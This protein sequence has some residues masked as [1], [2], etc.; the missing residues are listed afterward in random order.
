MSDKPKP[1]KK[2]LVLEM[3]A[4]V[5]LPTKVA[6]R[7]DALYALREKRMAYGRQITEAER[8]LSALKENE[9]EIARGLAKSLRELGGGTKLTGGVATFSPGS[10]DVFTVDDWDGFYKHIRENDAFDLLE[11]RP[12]RGALRERLDD[13]ALPPGIVHDTKFTYSLT[14]AT[15]KK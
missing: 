8:V 13:D 4:K 5:R 3:P 14:K 15:K 10:V 7:I 1:L 9:L 6:A 12:A 2:K 11:R